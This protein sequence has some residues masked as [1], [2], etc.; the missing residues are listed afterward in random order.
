VNGTGLQIH[1][2]PLACR[3]IVSAAR[4]QSPDHR[5][6]PKIFVI[7]GEASSTGLVALNVMRLD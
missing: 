1:G 5:R 6:R 3:S 4:Q 7:D 2:M